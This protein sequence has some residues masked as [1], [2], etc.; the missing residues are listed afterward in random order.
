LHKR[1]RQVAFCSSRPHL[2]PFIQKTTQN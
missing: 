1:K 2:L